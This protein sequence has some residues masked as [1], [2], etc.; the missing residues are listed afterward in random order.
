VAD[1][2]GLTPGARLLD[3]GC[4]PGPLA[5]GFARLGLEVV[6]VDPEPAM[7]EAA[8]AAAREAGVEVGLRRGSSFDL[9]ADLGPLRAVAIGRAF[10]WMER[11]AT[12][13]V[14]DR[15]VE[16]GGAVVLFGERKLDL[17]ANRWRQ[18]FEAVVERYTAEDDV[19]HW[20]H[21]GEGW[22]PHE[23]PLLASPFDDLERLGR[24]YR[25]TLDLDAAVGRAL[26]LSLTAPDALGERLPAFERE[27]REALTPFL[28]DGL[29]PEVVEGEALIA[30]RSH[31][32]P[33]HASCSRAAERLSM[34]VA[35]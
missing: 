2:C 10:H 13:A 3:L 23:E 12:L 29:L 18:A 21:R 31:E 8:A 5:V 33:L 35:D 20:G 26:S 32:R 14:L 28:H 27:L 6:V 7:L 25:Q 16:P 22:V 30:R 17:A 4:R 11:P 24:V 34:T 9:P 1:L 19:A 15:L